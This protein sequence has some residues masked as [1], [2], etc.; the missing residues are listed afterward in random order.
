MNDT[1][2]EIVGILDAG[3]P[4]LQIA[5]AQILGELRVKDP[6]V[7]RSLAN[8]VGRSN[9]LGRYV[10][11][12][13]GR[14]GTA[15]AL[16]VVVRALCE[17]DSLADQAIHLLHEAGPA[18]HPAVADAFGDAQPERRL[19]LLQVLARS[20]SKD[21]IRPFVQSLLTPETCQIAARLILEGAE[22]LVA[23]LP[24]LLREAIEHALEQPLPDTCMVAAI[25]VAAKVDAAGSRA[26]LQKFT[27][28]AVSASVRAAALR[29]MAGQKLSAAV[30]KSLLAQLE[31]PL[32]KPAHDAIRDLLA[33][34]TEWPEGL[35]PVMKRLLSARQ[36]EQRLFAM[37]ILRTSPMPELI[38]LALKLRDHE[39]ARFRAAA[40]DVLGAN[41]LAQEPLLRLLQ[42]CKDPTEGRRL[43]ALLVRHGAA[44]QPKAIR[45]IAERSI[46]L[47]HVHSV[48]GDFLCDI[49]IALGGAKMVPF[50]LEKAVRWRRT[51]H[52]PEALHLLAKLATANLL[53]NEGRFQLALA[54]FLQDSMRVQAEDAAPG[55]AAMGFFAALLR[56]GFA[57][58]ERLKKE[59][60]LDPDHLLR[61]ATYFAETVGPERRFGQELL[62]YLAAK[63]RGR[64][65]DGARLALR[66]AG[67]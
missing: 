50:F 29:G 61:L 17:H 24:K 30:V 14:L 18:A 47:M 54:R 5:A 39:D 8:A 41:K 48:A 40:E 12:S 36:P 9:V 31:D 55:N 45:A 25:D 4:E 10:L 63:N 7:I 66:T 38:K 37:R 56:E 16:K 64:A 34:Q 43:S 60:S 35:G 23:P 26:L 57:L 13:L 58:F 67:G 33:A 11:E 6:V 53:D 46:K 3:R 20:P 21:S 62:Q 22:R 65:G 32:Q 2:K 15:E 42:A 44:I 19:R 28:D 49:A 27:G 59:P 1:V 52:Y 51:K